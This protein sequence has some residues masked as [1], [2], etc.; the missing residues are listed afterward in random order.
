M[1]LTYLLKLN[2]QSNSYCINSI[3]K[4]GKS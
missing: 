1:N 2:N 4:G 3:T